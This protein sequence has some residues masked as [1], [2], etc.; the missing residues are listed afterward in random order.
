MPQSTSKAMNT[1][2]VDATEV[3]AVTGS[4]YPEPFHSRVGEGSWRALGD[5]FGLTQFGVSHETLKPGAQ[6][7]VNH[8]HTLADEFVWVVS[9]E[10]VLRLDGREYVMRTGSCVGFKAG[11]PLGHNFVN[12]SSED[13]VFVVVGTRLADDS[14][15]YP[16]DDLAIQRR[17]GRRQWVHKDGRPY[18]VSD[19]S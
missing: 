8:W 9:G 19:P 4:G 2:P 18:D 6:S 11:T 17:E 13:A 15:H 16:E 12:R 14:A 10:I 3:P 5:R 7:S 1:L